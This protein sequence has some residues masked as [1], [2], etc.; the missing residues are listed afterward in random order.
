MRIPP[1]AVPLHAVSLRALRLGLLC[2][3][4]VSAA[5]GCIMLAGGAA[6]GGAM[7]LS[8][9]RSVG[10]Q[11]ED[12]QIEHRINT[13]LDER[14][15]RL[16]VRIDVTSYRQKVLLAGQVPTQKDRADA[17]ALARASENVQQVTNDLS[18]GSLAGL[19]SHIDDDLLAGK[20]RAA[21]L[22]VAGLPGGITT[23]R[24]TNGI[25]YLFGRVGTEEAELAKRAASHTND[26]KRVVALFDL[27]S[28]AELQKFRRDEKNV[29]V[30]PPAGH[31][32]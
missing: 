23:V 10:I 24:C 2:A 9:R 13:A 8:D 18:I 26:V 21:L 15:A 5:S 30:L 1:Q 31:E 17:E 19:N 16:S 28:D 27:L 6:V 22:D 29:P 14:F 7:V 3:A 20:V 32:H 4:I 12:A 25:I 11:V